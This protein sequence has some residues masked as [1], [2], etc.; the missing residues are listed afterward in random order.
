VNGPDSSR[1]LDDA[2]RAAEARGVVVVVSAGN[3]SAN[4]DSVPSY[5]ASVASPAVVSVASTTREG[6]LAQA[7]AHGAASVDLAAPGDNVLTT[8]A[9]GRY[10]SRSG[11]SFAA[12]HVSG[13]AALLAAASPGA[14]GDQ[15]RE[16]LVA[17]TRRSARLDGLVASGQL[18]VAA[19]VQ[20]L[21][22]GAGPKVK[23]EPRRAASRCAASTWRARG[24]VGAIASYRVRVDGH[25]A[26]VIASSARKGKSCTRRLHPGRNRLRV[27]ALDPA[28]K[29]LAT[30][31][32][33]V[34]V[35]GN[36]KAAR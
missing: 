9:G 4:R 1:A 17:S 26:V 30:L 18:D 10:S 15:L 8:A 3:D 21:V 24:D 25:A 22:P 12:A 27:T 28:G 6:S 5:P 7:S 19:A 34:R 32:L 23:L 13:A 16:A 31:A 20:R 29:A 35:P 36:G 2:I 11:T 14:S 33:T